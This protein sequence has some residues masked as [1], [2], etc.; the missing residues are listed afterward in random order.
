MEKE[1]SPDLL[2]AMRKTGI[3]FDGSWK[4]WTVYEHRAKFMLE[5]FAIHH[6]DLKIDNYEDFVVMKTAQQLQ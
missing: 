6:Y 2:S 3:P 1:T 5:V 4:G